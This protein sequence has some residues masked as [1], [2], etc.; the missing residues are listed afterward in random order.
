MRLLDVLQRNSIELIDLYQNGA[1]TCELGR[2]YDCSNALVFKFLKKNNVEIRRTKQA[3][4]HR[5]SIIKMHNEGI[6]ATK[7]SKELKIG[8]NTVCRVLSKAGIDISDKQKKREDPLT[9]HKDEIVQ[10][11]TSGMTSTE[12][13]KKFNCIDSSIINR[14]RDWNIECRPCSFYK[15]HFINENFFEKIDTEEKA[16]IFGFFCADC[17]VN[18]SG[19]II[20]SIIDKEIAVKI[21]NIM[22]YSCE[23]QEM[24]GKINKNQDGFTNKQYRMHFCSQ[25]MRDDLVRLGCCYR[26]TYYLDFP[27]FN[28]VPKNLI[29]SYLL[30]LQDGDGSIYSS[31]SQWAASICGPF[32]LC[33]G[34]ND[35]I[36]EELNINGY[37]YYHQKCSITDIYIYRIA[38][39]T[40]LK[41]Y[42]DWL[43]KDATIYMERKH[44]K[45]LEFCD[46]YNTKFNHV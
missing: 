26:K 5:D 46:F 36:K 2:K 29:K 38:K 41:T 28:Q 33:K 25:K 10:M 32:N 40:D 19:S 23:L 31:N 24:D 3:D 42:L 43:Y 13:A 9:N 35:F 37:V 4:F 7:I 21:A 14:L 11:Y 27:N 44:K 18:E 6:S 8:Q 34:I 39:T 30:G 12:I 20:F 45:Y 15:T 22:K 16:Y 17:H 1:T